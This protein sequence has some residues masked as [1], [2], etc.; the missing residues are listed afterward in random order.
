M[1]KGRALSILIPLTLVFVIADVLIHWSEPVRSLAMRI[2]GP[3]LRPHERRQDRM[4]L[5]GASYVLIG[6]CITIAIFPKLIA[7]T[8]LAIL[9]VSDISAALIGRRYGRHRLF[10]KT[11]EGTLAFFVAALIVI[12]VI[13]SL[14][15]LAAV[16]YI[17]AA[18]A[19]AV[20]AIVENISI[21]LKMDDNISIPL[22]IG[23][24]MWAVAEWLPSGEHLL[25]IQ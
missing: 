1:S 17:V 4:L 11:L 15:Q 5:N 9:I 12:G 14:Y 21:R 3:L 25:G 2:V 16:Y 20:G 10:D 24:V 22:S 13:G 8:A 23:I 7:V 18:I 19:A 6:A